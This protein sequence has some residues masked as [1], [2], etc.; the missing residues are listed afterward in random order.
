MDIGNMY[1][2]YFLS[3]YAACLASLLPCAMAKYKAL[4]RSRRD[5]DD[6][7]DSSVT[8]IVIICAAISMSIIVGVLVY[9]RKKCC[10]D[11]KGSEGNI[12]NRNRSAS[13]QNLIEADEVGI[14][15]PDDGNVDN[16]TATS[17]GV[18]NDTSNEAEPNNNDS[19]GTSEPSITTDSSALAVRFITA[20]NHTDMNSVR[21]SQRV[22]PPRI[23]Q[24]PPTYQSSVIQNELN[25]NCNEENTSNLNQ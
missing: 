14:V 6:L 5:G 18:S 17:P 13:T 11:S 24:E 19:D 3:I 25:N 8:A 4:P 22:L 15:V 10:M 16:L 12:S 21:P 20:H 1:N 23:P 9:V 2:S 7:G